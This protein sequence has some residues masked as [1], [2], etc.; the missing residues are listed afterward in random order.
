MRP[1]PL[2]VK[3]GVLLGVSMLTG[4][5]AVTA[6]AVLLGEYVATVRTAPVDQQ[7]LAA[8]EKAVKTDESWMS[9]LMAERDRQTR[10]SLEREA[11]KHITGHGLILAAAAFLL[12]L[13][14]FLSLGDRQVPTADQIAV[15]RAGGRHPG[16]KGKSGGGELA[17]GNGGEA[18]RQGEGRSEID[19][20]FIDE[21]I[22]GTGRDPEAAIPLLQAIQA[23]FRY[24]PREALERVCERTK[25]TPAQIE[26]V[27]SFYTQ[28]R[29]TPVG[30]HLVKVCHGTACHVAG[31]QAVSDE[32]RR[33]LGIRPGEDTDAARRFTIEPVACMGCCTLAPVIQVD[34]VVHGHVGPDDALGWL[35]ECLTLPLGGRRP[36]RHAR[37]TAARHSGRDREPRGE[38]RVG[39]GSCCVAGGSG[40]VYEAFARELADTGVMVS[41]KRVGCVG[42]CHRTP[43][44]EAILPGR[45]PA[46]YANV[47]HDDVRTIVERHF[48]PAGMARKVR[49]LASS[50]VSQWRGNGSARS[51]REMA[52]SLR[53]PQVAAFLGRQVRIA[54]EHN[55][56]I[57]PTDLEEYRRH[58]G[59]RALDRC[60]KE[61]T[62][63]QI[64][65]QV[66]RSGLRGR[67]GAGFPTGRKWNAVRNASGSEK[68]VICN[69]DEGD[70]GA[71]MDRMLM[72]S[73]P[74]RIIEGLAIAAIAVGAE[75]GYFY[76]RAEYPLAVKRIREA[77]RLCEERGLLGDNIL[78]GGHRLHLR[79]MEGAGAFVCGEETALIAS[80][81]GRRGM[82]SLR[83]PFPAESGLWG[84]PTLVSNV[85]TYANVPW[86]IRHGAD[87]FAVMGTATSKG[88]KV[89][90]L[91]GKVNRG[92]LIE[93]PMGVTIRQIVEEIGG[94]I[95]N[96]RRFKA[97]QIGG[98]S[99]GCIP[100][101]LADTPVDYEA[102]R[103]VGAIMGSGGLVVMDESDCMVDIARYFLAFTQDQSCGKCTFCRVGT[104]RMLDILDRLCAGKGAEADLDSLEELARMVCAGSLC[105]LGKTAPNPVLT[106][107]RYFRHEYEAHLEGRCPA[108]KCKA[109]IRYAVSD[110]CIGCTLCAQACPVDAIPF[111]PYRRHEIDD[112]RCT[113]CDAC[114]QKCPENAI[115][116]ETGP[117]PSAAAMKAGAA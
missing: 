20:A 95:R 83:P 30:E 13:K 29:R 117:R 65:D 105:G 48:R 3:R 42:M 113:R 79:I 49:R 98:P 15:E 109:L 57:D 80:I 4:L 55:G 43:L 6:I 63:P 44:V 8:L 66:T 108:G 74:F 9:A 107:L 27:A 86:I 96:G 116:I 5:A 24:L 37:I 60:V 23:R 56:Q 1:V 102:L 89:F 18:R 32:I 33:H 114:R 26:G 70:P 100:A 67:G 91:A 59:F 93:V 16:R 76:I 104:R 97:V 50:L 62:N 84:K 69:G 41:V 101:E 64:I 12:S 10:A 78:G 68:Y 99:G 94:G 25:I 75:Q 61:L 73:F 77:I 14:G 46:L 51:A 53:D 106:T 92:G 11:H 35:D 45:E 85:E 112:S 2:R 40:K 103:E 54:T 72:E 21:A 52:I 19:L 28:F 47:Q 90:A 82:P 87:E 36:S 111:A 115:V 34:D 17:C 31:A 22:A 38:L 39:L 71:F 110:D 7:T 88:T 81:E 58:D